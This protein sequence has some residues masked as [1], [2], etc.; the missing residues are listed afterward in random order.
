MTESEQ[1]RQKNLDLVQR[2]QRGDETAKNEVVAQNMPLVRSIAKHFNDR[3]VDFEDLVQIGVIGMYRAVQ[4]F[5]FTF[6]TAFSTYAV[7]LIVGEIRRYLRDDGMLKVSRET[8]KQGS[9]VLRIAQ[10]LRTE[11]GREPTVTEL[12]EKTG[13][14]EAALVFAMEGVLPVRSLSEPV[15]RAQR[16]L[17]LEGTLSD[18]CGQMERLCEKLTL[19]EAIAKLDKTERNVVYLRYFK[20]LTQAQTARVLGLTQVKI[21]RMEKRIFSFLRAQM[22]A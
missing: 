17:T 1:R 5:D 20:D 8:K 18:H 10:Q 22:K 3:G 21:S 15:D 12:C 6:K 2:A 13:L 11:K 19:R 4:S 14:D 7:P 16:E 9:T